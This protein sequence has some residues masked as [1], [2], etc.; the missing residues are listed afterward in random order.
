MGQEGVDLRLYVLQV[1]RVGW[2]LVAAGATRGIV[3]D[4]GG[5]T[6]EIFVLCKALS[7]E[8]IAYY[9]TVDGEGLAQSVGR[10]GLGDAQDE[11]RVDATE[12]DDAD[13]CQSQ[14]GYDMLFH[15]EFNSFKCFLKPV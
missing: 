10:C 15:D 14:G 12:E 9:F 5:A 2:S 11:Y 13:G 6:P 1:V 8:G 7:F 3:T 4:G